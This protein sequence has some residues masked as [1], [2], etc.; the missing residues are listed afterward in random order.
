MARCVAGLL[1][2]RRV[3]SVCA[4]SFHVVLAVTSQNFTAS[5][6]AEGGAIIR[7]EASTQADADIITNTAVESRERVVV[8]FI[9]SSRCITLWLPPIGQAYNVSKANVLGPRHLSATQPS[10]VE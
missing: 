8:A 3:T 9:N 1:V 6:V 4:R 5:R 10:L 7:R 2:D